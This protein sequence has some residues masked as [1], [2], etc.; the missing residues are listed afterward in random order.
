MD[1]DDLE[2]VL[3]EF[4]VRI[5]SGDG[6]APDGVAK[7]SDAISRAALRWRSE[8]RIE[9]REVAVLVAFFPD[10]EAASWSYPEAIQEEIYDAVAQLNDEV[11]EALAGDIREH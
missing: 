1:A 3:T 9:R 5:R 6:L 8:D 4:A 7:C 10:V 2:T 11:L